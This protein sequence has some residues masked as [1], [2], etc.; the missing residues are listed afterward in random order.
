MMTYLEHVNRIPGP[1]EGFIVKKLDSTHVF[2]A[3]SMA[4]KI[5]DLVRKHM[6]ENQAEEKK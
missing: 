2:I 6:K 1:Y 5:K 4:P 3:E